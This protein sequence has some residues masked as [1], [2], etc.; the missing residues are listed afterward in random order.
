MAQNFKPTEG[1]VWTHPLTHTR[2]VIHSITTDGWVRYRSEGANTYPLYT[3]PVLDFTKIYVREETVTM[4]ATNIISE[5]TR[6]RYHGSL[7][8]YHGEMTV[9]GHHKELSPTFGEYSPVRYVLRYGPKMND[10]IHNVRPES[11]T[12]INDEDGHA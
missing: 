1:E 8:A 5:G 10:A 11:F 2:W 3:R 12:V 9:E 6:V 7:S 4:P